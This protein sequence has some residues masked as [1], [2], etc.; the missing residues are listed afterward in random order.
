MEAYVN[1]VS[2]RKVDRLV[3]QLGIGGMTKD[4]VSALSPVPKVAELLAAA[5]EDLLAFFSAAPGR[6][7]W[8]YVRRYCRRGRPVSGQTGLHSSGRG[9]SRVSGRPVAGA[10]VQ[11]CGR[12]C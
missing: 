6:A 8:R 12:N 9:H 11:K 10:L 1:G 5:K 4:R 3:G 2:T 7:G